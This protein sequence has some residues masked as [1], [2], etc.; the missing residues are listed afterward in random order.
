M[1]PLPS[2]SL[3]LSVCVYAPLTLAHLPRSSRPTCLLL[4]AS[5]RA[6]RTWTMLPSLSMPPR[7]AEA[8]L[9]LTASRPSP[10]HA[11]TPRVAVSASRPSTRR[12]P[13]WTRRSHPPTIGAR[14][15][16]STCPSPLRSPRQG[17]P[18]ASPRHPSAR[19]L[20]RAIPPHVSAP[21]RVLRGNRGRVGG[22]CDWE[23][24]GR[25]SRASIPFVEPLDLRG[26]ARSQGGV[27]SGCMGSGGCV[28][29]VS[30]EGVR[31]GPC[32][33]HESV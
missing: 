7:E 20:H 21:L 8:P 3:S 28:A 27:G 1:P 23:R 17:I 14:C 9:C 33:Q 32:G 24:V 31:F 30:R 12:L 26:S 11:I 19:A 5:D 25:Q 15:K 4:L 10:S 2:L 13:P 29:G 22:R 16:H 6:H 18:Q